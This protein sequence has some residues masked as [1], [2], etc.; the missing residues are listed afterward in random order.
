MATLNQGILGGFSGKVGPVVGSNWRGKNVLRSAPTKSTKPISPAQQRQ[1]DKFKCVLQF[2]TPIKGIITETFGVAVGSKSPFNQA[3]SYHMREAVQ[4]T[5]TGF[6]IDY[7]KV[8]VVII[9][10]TIK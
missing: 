9:T 10:K 3:M 4:Q 6:P 2:L 8:L 7:N 5:P 1:R